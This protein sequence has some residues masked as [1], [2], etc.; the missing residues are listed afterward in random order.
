MHIMLK[1]TKTTKS[2][3]GLI[4]FEGDNGIGKTT[5]GDIVTRELGAMRVETP[6]KGYGGIR[7]YVNSRGSL[8]G[9]FLY[10]LSSV[11]DASLEIEQALKKGANVVCDRYAASSFVDFLILSGLSLERL[12]SFY[13]FIRERLVQPEATILLR[14]SHEERLRRIGGRGTPISSRDN[15]TKDYSDKTDHF[16]DSIMAREKNW[17]V[18]DTTKQKE[19]ETAAEVL[20][21]VKDVLAIDS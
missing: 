13:G 5:I 12:D 6:T 15:M 8:T 9:T 11:F 7:D 21:I 4:V 20:K 19:E 17:H 10:Y 16:Y 1:M 3:G 2:R 18:L 14:C